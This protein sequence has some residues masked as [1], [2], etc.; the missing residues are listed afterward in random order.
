MLNIKTDYFYDPEILKQELEKY[1]PFFTSMD[2]LS[3]LY[4]PTRK[5]L[6]EPHLQCIG[7]SPLDILDWNFS[8][9]SPMFQNSNFIKLIEQINKPNERVRL[10]RMRPKS[11]YSVHIDT[12][13]RLHWA[14]IT[15]PECHMSFQIADNTFTGFHIPADGYGYLVDTRIKHTALNPTQEFR[16]HLV[17][18]II[19]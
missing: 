2:Q 7:Q 18:D 17:I 5:L 15:F 9:I 14:L 19:E 13:R 4:D 6:E 11:C 10:M 16:Y 8:E 3:L 12:Y 1:K